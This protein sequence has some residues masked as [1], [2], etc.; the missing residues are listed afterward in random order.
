VCT[1]AH[2]TS[3]CGLLQ[4]NKR[5]EELHR[6]QEKHPEVAARLTAKVR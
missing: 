3:V 6:L 5:R 2:V 1:A 4:Y